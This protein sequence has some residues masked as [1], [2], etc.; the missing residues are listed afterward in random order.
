LAYVA[1]KLALG[2]DLVSVRNSVTKTTTACFEPSLDYV[3]AKVP[4]WDLKKFQ[5][6]SQALGSSMKSVG[7]VMAIGRSFEEVIQKA[8]RMVDPSLDGFGSDALDKAV[9]YLGDATLDEQLCQP[10]HLRLFAVARALELGCVARFGC[11]GTVGEGGGGKS[12]AAHKVLG[13]P[14]PRAHSHRPMVRG[15]RR[16]PN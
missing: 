11:G 5:R 2:K 8:V 13:G 6:V 10:T 12:D 9:S 7:E 4:R 15:L 1:A 16:W 3:V 14:N